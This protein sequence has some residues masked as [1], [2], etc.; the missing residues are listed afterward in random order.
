MF[1]DKS[2]KKDV[3]HSRT[4]RECIDPPELIKKCLSCKRPKCRNCIESMKAAERYAYVHV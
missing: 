2:L 1:K 4:K 3:S